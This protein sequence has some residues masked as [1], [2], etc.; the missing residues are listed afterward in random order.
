MKM[1]IEI[2]SENVRIKICN[3]CHTCDILYTDEIVVCIIFL[4]MNNQLK[5]ILILLTVF[6]LNEIKYPTRF[7]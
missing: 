5:K 6:L 1:N 2:A 3:F 7:L 4:S